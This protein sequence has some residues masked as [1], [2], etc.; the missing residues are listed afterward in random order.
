M[1]TLALVLPQAAAMAFPGV[2]RG[3]PLASPEGGSGHLLCLEQLL[4]LDDPTTRLRPY[5][6]IRK[7]NNGE[8]EHVPG[9]ETREQE[10][11]KMRSAYCCTHG[12]ST[13]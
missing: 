10:Q 4:H 3:A 13:L 11:Q 1:W 5:H 2:P 6:I 7:G 8:R 9:D 12:L